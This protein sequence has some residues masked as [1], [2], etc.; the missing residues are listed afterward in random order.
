PPSAPELLST[1]IE[2][3]DTENICGEEVRGELHALERGAGDGTRD[4]F[5]QGGFA[6]ARNIFDENVATRGERG[7]DGTDGIILTADNTAHGIFEP[8]GDGVN[9]SGIDHSEV[10]SGRVARSAAARSRCRSQSAFSSSMASC[11]RTVATRSKIPLLRSSRGRLNGAARSSSGN[12]RGPSR[13][14]TK[15]RS[16]YE[17]EP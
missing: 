17:T 6:R 1:R 13:V 16:G 14:L 3:R 5:G 12:A 7:E 15:T 4:G 8:A 11:G 9:T 2:H 10:G